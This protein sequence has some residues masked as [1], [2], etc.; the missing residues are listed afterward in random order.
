MGLD[1]AWA[2]GMGAMFATMGVPAV[3]TRPAPA[4]TPIETSL[5]WVERTTPEVPD[6]ARV[7]RHDP[8]RIGVLSS[9]DVPS[10]PT[11]TMVEAA[12]TQDGTAQRWKVDGIARVDADQVRVILLPVT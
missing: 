4:D 6:G 2:V 9:A 3:V 11:G 5:I 1:A 7:T 10:I 12:D 8:R